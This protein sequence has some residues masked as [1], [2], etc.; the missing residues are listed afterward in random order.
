MFYVDVEL[1][2]ENGS[3]PAAQVITECTAGL[4]VSATITEVI[5]NWTMIRF[6]SDDHDALRVAQ[7]RFWDDL[8]LSVTELDDA[9]IAVF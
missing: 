2:E 6:S 8:Q 3:Q 1:V 7:Q 4:P 5:N 9:I